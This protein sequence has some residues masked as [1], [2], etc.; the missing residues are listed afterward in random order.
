MDAS[1]GFLSRGLGDAARPN[2]CDKARVSRPRSAPRDRSPRLDLAALVDL[3]LQLAADEGFSEAELFER[4]RSI[5]LSIPEPSPSGRVLLA[6]WVEAIGASKAP[7]P[8]QALARAYRRASGLLGLSMFVVGAF[9][10]FG[11][12]HFTGEHPI[13]VLVVLGVFVFA[14]LLM[15]ALSIIA[16]L[17]AALSPGVFAGLPLVALLRSL[18][19]WLWSR[20]LDRFENEDVRRTLERLSTRRPLYQRL[21]RHV[22][23]RHLQLGAIWFNLG[24]LTV[25][26]VDVT[27]TDLAFGWSTTLQIGPDSFH[28]LCSTLAAPWSPWLPQAVPSMELVGAT[29]YFRLEGAYV[30][31]F[32][33]DRTVDP[34]MS[35]QWW[36][37][38]ASC[39]VVYGLLPRVLLAIWSSIMVSLSVRAVPLDT[40]DIERL[41]ARLE[42]PS[43]RRAHGADPGDV[44]PLGAGMAAVPGATAAD[45]GED[46]LGILW[47]D[48]QCSEAN[49][50]RFLRDQYHRDLRGELGVAGSSD[51]NEDEKVIGRLHPKERSPVLIVS[52]PWT[53]PDASLRRLVGSIRARG[54]RRPILFALTEGGSYDDTAIWAGYLAELRD[55]YVYFE[56]DARVGC[57][58]AS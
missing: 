37:F 1:V 36:M 54:E 29:Q 31:A 50:R 51:F 7:S 10:A 13:N 28:A 22:L 39:L 47:R 20:A 26:L 11:I 9:T 35:G 52:E 33:G 40:P 43:I 17:A 6:R 56:R 12:F 3:E 48:A 46:A 41:L 5:A 34:A 14:Q 16:L 2:S 55:P 30:G 45:V 19:S 57:G 58:M 42:A 8:G 21:E 44:T 18:A 38:L 27:V 23:F 25:L 15:A 24:A 32:D 53:A 4:D 49:V